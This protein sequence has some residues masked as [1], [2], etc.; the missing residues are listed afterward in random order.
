MHT[1]ESMSHYER[2]RAIIESSPDL[3][4]DLHVQSDGIPGH[5]SVLALG[6]VSPNG[7]TFY[8]E[9]VPEGYDHVT[10]RRNFWLEH[11]L[12][13][14]QLRETGEHT[15]DFMIRFKRWIEETKS[16][17]DKDRAIFVSFDESYDYPLLLSKYKKNNIPPDFQGAHYAVRS[18]ATALR[19]TNGYWE[20]DSHRLRLPDD[21]K[22]EGE[23]THNALQDAVFQQK[24]HYM[25][26]GK[27]A[28]GTKATYDLPAETD[29]ALIFELPTKMCGSRPEPGSRQDR[30][31]SDTHYE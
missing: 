25:L 11:G 4:I 29:Q 28:S 1:P 17:Q 8:S 20:D 2:G 26:L 10:R 13:R 16:R 30:R 23:L 27:I 18:L 7:D 22:A 9:M 24:V 6:A 5:G 19:V 15:R 21:C 14:R 12:D 3:Y 31:L